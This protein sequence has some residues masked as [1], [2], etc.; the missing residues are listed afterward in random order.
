MRV[1]AYQ[2]EFPLFQGEFPFLESPSLA[3]LGGVLGA[4]SWW[5][6]LHVHSVDLTPIPPF[7]Y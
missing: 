1:E 2:Y 6:V 7:G 3:G 5:A 4:F